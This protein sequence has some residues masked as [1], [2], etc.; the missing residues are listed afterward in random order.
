MAE[1]REER[2]ARIQASLDR[3]RARN[4]DGR[5][6]AVYAD[7]V[8]WLLSQASAE[9]RYRVEMALAVNPDGVPVSWIQS[10][11]TDLSYP[12][13][14]EAREAMWAEVA[15]EATERREDGVEDPEE[16]GDHF[17][18]TS[19]PVQVWTVEEESP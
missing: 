3:Y 4:G 6:M 8:E 11:W 15:R 18:I 13:L 16:A 1:S 2:L 17:R 19:A 5:T 10:G 14:A 7:D 9:R 12:S